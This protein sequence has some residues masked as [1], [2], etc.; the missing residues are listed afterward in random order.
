MGS[1]GR[2]CV[3]CDGFCLTSFFSLRL[4]NGALGLP[5]DAAAVLSNVL[6]RFAAYNLV[7]PTVTIGPAQRSSDGTQYWTY[8]KL[9]YVDVLPPDC[10][11]QAAA[12]TLAFGPGGDGLAAAVTALDGFLRPITVLSLVF[13]A[14]ACTLPPACTAPCP[15]CSVETNRQGLK[16]CLQST[17]DRRIT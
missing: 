12:A 3:P 15:P 2:C 13:N 5:P 7:Q 9:A 16:C 11:E 1:T 10:T 4:S 17:K 14:F 6:K 8:V